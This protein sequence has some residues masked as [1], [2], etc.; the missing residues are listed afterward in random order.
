LA[1]G[2]TLEEAGP[3]VRDPVMLPAGGPA[4]EPGG[5]AAHVMIVDH[6]GNLVTDLE[7]SAWAE[8]LTPGRFTIRAG[9]LVLRKLEPS[10]GHVK[11]GG[12]LAYWGSASTLEV[13]IN[14]GSAAAAAGLAPGATIQIEWIG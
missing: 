5:L 10:F 2:W 9:A 8:R 1:G 4:V 12:P 6:F 3:L 7:E 14:R 13:A 11:I